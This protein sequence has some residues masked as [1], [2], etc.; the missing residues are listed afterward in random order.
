MA[1]HYLLKSLPSDKKG[2]LNIRGQVATPLEASRGG[3]QFA[4]IIF[5]L[6]DTL[7]QNSNKPSLNDA[8]LRALHTSSLWSSFA[9]YKRLRA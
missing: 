4:P 8:K 7:N 3:R 6:S 5:N 2:L 1:L 9:T